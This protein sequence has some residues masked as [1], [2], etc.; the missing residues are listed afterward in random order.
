MPHRRKPKKT[1]VLNEKSH[2]CVKEDSKK[3]SETDINV[4]IEDNPWSRFFTDMLQNKRDVFEAVFQGL[5]KTNGGEMYH[6]VHENMIK[7]LE[8]TFSSLSPD[9]QKLLQKNTSESIYVTSEILH[10]HILPTINRF[11]I[12]NNGYYIRISK[13]E[14]YAISR[15]TW[16]LDKNKSTDKRTAFF[17]MYKCNNEL[18]YHLLS[19][20]G[21]L[22]DQVIRHLTDNCVYSHN[23]ADQITRELDI[24]YD[25]VS[26]DDKKEEGYRNEDVYKLIVTVSTFIYG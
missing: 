26:F 13:N 16:E 21:D 23:V 19:S 3:V 2:V 4:L 10:K 22:D 8:K 9:F 17:M 11:I 15:K 7:Y 6:I 14:R 20:A 24:E 12:Y 1:I 25:F 5:G 18:K